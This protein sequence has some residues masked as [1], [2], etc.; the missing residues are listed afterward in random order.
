VEKVYEKGMKNVGKEYET[1]RTRE[2]KG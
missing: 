2:G 1:G